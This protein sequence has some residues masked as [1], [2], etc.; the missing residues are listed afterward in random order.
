MH[1]AHRICALLHLSR[2]MGIAAAPCTSQVAHCRVHRP[3]MKTEAWP[4]L[5][6]KLIP[7][8]PI[9]HSA[10]N[11]VAQDDDKRLRHKPC[12][13]S[14]WSCPSKSRRGSQRFV[15]SNL[16]PKKPFKLCKHRWPTTGQSCHHYC[17]LRL[18]KL[19]RPPSTKNRIISRVLHS[20]MLRRKRCRNFGITQIAEFS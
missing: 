2:A 7:K 8:S 3:R 19:V 18:S 1:W 5:M 15:R 11:S 12:N 4:R 9:H 20:V 13:Q 14:T 16:H 6:G 17:V 10:G